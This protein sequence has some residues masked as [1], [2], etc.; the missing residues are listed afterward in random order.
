MKQPEKQSCKQGSGQKLRPALFCHLHD[1]GIG[2]RGT[3]R[4]TRIGVPK[5]NVNALTKK[6]PQGTIRWIREG[7][8]LYIKWMDTREVSVCSTLH[9]AFSGDTVKRATK[10]GG[11]H[12][13]V[14]VPVPSAVKD[15]NSVM[16]GVDLSDQLIGS[17]SSGR[18][19]KKLYLTVLHHSIDIA[20]TNSYLL[21]KELCGRLEQQPMTHQA[22]Q[23]QLIGEL[24]GVP[25]QRVPESYQHI[26]VAIVEGVS[27]SKKATEGRRKCKLCGKCTPFMCEACKVPLCVIVDRNCHKIFHSSPGA[28]EK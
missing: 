2:A 20:V 9:T 3:F 4:A 23:E 17:Y 28:S 6:S 24:C 10:V 14:Q 1:L 11:R 5:T 13:A 15:Y 16:G 25:S 21:H 22:F 19:S 7:A 26:P 27:G 12:A 8:L 18:K